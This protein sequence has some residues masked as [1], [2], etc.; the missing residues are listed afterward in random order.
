MQCLLAAECKGREQLSSVWALHSILVSFRNALGV[1]VQ[2]NAVSQRYFALCPRHRCNSF[3][4]LGNDDPLSD[5]FSLPKKIWFYT[6]RR[7]KHINEHPF[8]SPPA[9]LTLGFYIFLLW[10]QITPC[11]DHDVVFIW[12]LQWPIWWWRG[13]ISIPQVNYQMDAVLSSWE[14]HKMC[15]P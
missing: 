8:W 15:I 2:I 6:Q 9:I 12:A 14:K 13:S 7:G 5:G 11:S 10:D 1:S 4:T 3:S